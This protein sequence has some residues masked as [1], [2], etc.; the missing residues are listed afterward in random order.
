MGYSVIPSVKTGI[1]SFQYLG[2]FWIPACAGMTT[3]YGFIK[4]EFGK[5]RVQGAKDSRARAKNARI[6]NPP[7]PRPDRKPLRRGKIPRIRRPN[8]F[9]KEPFCIIGAAGPSPLDRPPRSP[10]REPPGN[11]PRPGQG[12]QSRRPHPPGPRRDR[13]PR[14]GKNLL[15]REVPG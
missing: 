13:A 7:K 1:Q 9:L 2:R 15:P 12:S 5:N 14:V 3:F 11:P 8:L 6:N 4:R 10:R